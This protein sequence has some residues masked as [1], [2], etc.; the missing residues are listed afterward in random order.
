VVLFT[1]Y[2]QSCVSTEKQCF[3]SK[4]LIPLSC[5]GGSTVC[6]LWTSVRRSPFCF[7]NAVSFSSA[8]EEMVSGQ[9]HFQSKAVSERSPSPTGG[10]QQNTVVRGCRWPLSI[11]GVFSCKQWLPLTALPELGGSGHKLNPRTWHSSCYQFI[12]MVCINDVIV[13]CTAPCDV[14]TTFLFYTWGD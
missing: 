6:D 4:I 12:W 1:L 7:M 2:I 10:A 11:A 9:H 5:F 3:E 14:G 8:S 13:V